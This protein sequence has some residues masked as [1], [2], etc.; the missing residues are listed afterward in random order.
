[1]DDSPT[2]D[3]DRRD[4][5]CIVGDKL[6]TRTRHDCIAFASRRWPQVRKVELREGSMGQ[7]CMLGE[8]IDDD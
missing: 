2:F 4:C 8:G 3:I 5:V 7:D 1:L 6:I